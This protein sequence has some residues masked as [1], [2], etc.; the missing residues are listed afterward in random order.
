MVWPAVFGARLVGV[1]R[2]T[3]ASSPALLLGPLPSSSSFLINWKM[4]P[5]VGLSGRTAKPTFL[6]ESLVMFASKH[7][8]TET[9]RDPLQ[10]ANCASKNL[11]ELIAR[12]DSRMGKPAES[13]GLAEQMQSSESLF[14]L[15]AGGEWRRPERRKTEPWK[16]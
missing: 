7:K 15:G 13:W 2:E 11:N 6:Q 10:I 3:D 14:L 16:L 9:H 8:R 4:D 12:D 1:V 5:T